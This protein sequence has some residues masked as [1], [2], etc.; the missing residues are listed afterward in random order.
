MKD[1]TFLHVYDVFSDFLEPWLAKTD[2]VFRLAKVSIVAFDHELRYRAWN[3]Y[4][5]ETTAIP[6]EQ[7][8]GQR[9]LDVFP[10]LR[11]MGIEDCLLRALGG[12]LVS[13]RRFSYRHH[14]TGELHSVEATYL[15]LSTPDRPPAIADQMPSPDASWLPPSRGAVAG[16]M[17]IARDLTASAQSAE[18]RREPSDLPPEVKASKLTLRQLSRHPVT[19]D[20][21]AT[22]SCR[23]REVLQLI[24]TGLTNS[25]IGQ[26]LFISKRTVE[27]HRSRVMQKLGLRSTVAL[28]HYALRRKLVATDE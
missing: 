11:A 15:P 17:F 10:G 14:V 9:A 20:P 22:L 12:E 13:L 26:R 1:T 8:K 25:Q 3:S 19:R 23:E 24:V 7:V 16:V 4:A 5:Q 2:L 6:W 28:V 27:Q 21:Y 18:G